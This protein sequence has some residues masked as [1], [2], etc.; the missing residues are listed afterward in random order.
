MTPRKS[1]KYIREKIRSGS[2]LPDALSEFIEFYDSIDIFGCSKKK[3]GDM[4]LF[5]FGG[6][7]DWT[8]YVQINLTRQYTFKVFGIYAGMKQLMMNVNYEAKILSLKEGNFWL[9]SEDVE[10]FKQ[11]VLS[12]EAVKKATSVAY[13]SIEFEYDSV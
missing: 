12:S 11:R 6:A 5:Q 13:A 9:E 3:H 10:E 8:P 2:T 4:L 7:Y 1:E